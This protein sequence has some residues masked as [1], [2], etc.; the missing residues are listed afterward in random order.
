M[1]PWSPT[2]LDR[3]ETALELEIA[4]RRGDGSLRQAVPVWVV[5]VGPHVYVRTWFRRDSGWFGQVLRSRRA[6]VRV[7][8]LDAEVAVEDVGAASREAVD[9][10]YRGKYGHFG[11]A[12]V[13]KMVNASASAST[14]RLIRP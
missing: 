10:A 9:A 4:A 8:G 3:F 13:E 12:T 7:E 6:R 2:E 11:A 5:R 1:T 14:L